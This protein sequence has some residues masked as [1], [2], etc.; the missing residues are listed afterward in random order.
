MAEQTEFRPRPKQQAVLAYTG[1]RMGV[2]AVP[3][4]GKTWTLSRLAAQLVVGGR[5]GDDQEVLIVTLVNSAVKNFA[6]R[7]AGFV[8]E[9]GLLPYVGYRVR[10]L[11]GLAHDIVR[12]RPGLVA[13]DDSFDIIDERGADE[14]LQEIALKWLRAHP[15]LADGFL[16]ADLDENAAQWTRRDKWPDLAVDVARSFI[17]Q[18]KDLQ[19]TPVQ[20]GYPLGQFS[21]P[22][23]LMEMCSQI[24][25]DY[26]RAL[27]FRGVVDFDDL[28]RL[29]LQALRL[30]PAFLERLRQRWPYILEDEAQDSSR[31]QELILADLAGPEGNWVRVG[32]PNQAIY[33]TFTTASP[34]HLRTFLGQQG[35]VSRDLPNSGRSMQSII[36]LANYFIDW[37]MEAHPVYALR[38]ALAPPHIEPTPEGD[39]QPN[40]P[41]HPEAVRLVDRAFTPQAELQ[42]V[43][44]SVGRWIAEHPEDTVAVLVPR[45]MRGYE[46]EGELKER[47]IACIEL[48]R[49]SRLT[50]EAAGALANIVRYLASPASARRLET[51]YRVWR[52][53]R[54]EDDDQRHAMAA[55]A[56]VISSCRQVEDYLWPRAGRDWLDTLE[57]DP[58]EVEPLRD[59]LLAF[60]SLVQRWHGATTLPIDQIILTL[61]QDLFQEP[62]DL[63]IAHKLA[64]VLRQT[65]DRHPEW[66]L[67]E[68]VEELAQVARNERKFLG[69]ADEDTGFNPDAYQGKV[70]VATIHK[71]KGLEWDKVYV[72]SANDYDFPSA[73]TQDVFISEPWYVRDRLNLQAEALAQ[74]RALGENPSLFI[75][76]EGAATAAA[77]RDYA[78]ERL[79]LFYVAI[80]RARK[81]LSVTWNT[82]QRG[83]ARPAVPFIA[84]QTWLEQQAAC[85]EDAG[86]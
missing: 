54:R 1:G 7:V 8:Q 67:P 10:T 71:A 75:Y 20:V 83:T 23:P 27:A 58:A 15:E 59:E 32:D 18:A 35:V 86:V 51:A 2:S 16:S 37:T 79:R 38:T 57:G 11:H 5:L 47:G 63:A 19:L 17:K 46:V 28:I 13:L 56:K 73:Q 14:V 6:G 24:Y 85:R 45:N 61:A 52:R 22:L 12:E 3:G 4:S 76:D 62:A 42:A 69:F 30:E 78:A 33:E 21:E 65:A 84:L 31:L 29:A 68:L 40:P 64:V 80:T 26:Q 81:A 82:G 25:A 43:A 50:R 53:E 77:R 48:L 74:L 34:E 9:A 41:D 72:M 49:S 60:R 70:V 66:R 55:V 39:P 36:D 44:D